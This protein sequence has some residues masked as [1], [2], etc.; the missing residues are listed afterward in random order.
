MQSLLVK[1]ND[2]IWLF[3]LECSSDWIFILDNSGSIGSSDFNLIREFVAQI[4]SSLEIGLQ[5]NLVSVISY[6]D[7]ASLHFGLTRHTDKSSLLQ[8]IRAVPYTG[9]GT[10]TAAAL[11]LLQNNPSLGLRNGYR[12]I[13]VFLTD[14]RS[15]DTRE[16]LRIASQIHSTN[17][18]DIISIGIG[19]ANVQELEGIASD[20][21]FVFMTVNFTLSAALNDYAN[22]ILMLVCSSK[23]LCAFFKSF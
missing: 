15:S 23:L 9:G 11:Q 6:A 14:G 16:T 21:N 3:S 13:V 17:I 10:N 7:S 4:S 8:A 20:S 19:N 18:Y 22:R 5:R 12:H 1:K 2:I